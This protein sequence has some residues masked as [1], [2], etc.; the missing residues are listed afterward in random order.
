M[1][2]VFLGTPRTALPTLEALVRSGHDVTRVVTRPD[3]PAGRSGKAI[4]PPVKVL[5]EELG[6]SV[7]QPGKIRGAAFLEELRE[8]RPEALVV[9][10]YGRI[11]PEP[12]LQLAPARAINLHF[13]LLPRYRGAAPVQWALANG[14]ESTG[15]TTM[16]ISARLDE[17]DLLLQEEVAIRN[18]E[19]NPELQER[20]AT[21][22]A[23]LVLRTL[24][25]QAAGKLDA[26]P[27]D[28]ARA[29][30]APILTAAD[31]EIDPG[32][33]A[34]EIE[35][36]VRGFD[37]WPGVWV[38]NGG[39]RLRLIEVEK[40]EQT[41]SGAPPGEVLEL[42]GEGLVVACGE[43]TRLSVIRIQPEGR[44]VIRARDAVNGRQLRPGDRLEKLE[45]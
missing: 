1:R 26:R 35:G 39:R 13:S 36:R 18:G 42:A 5:A 23:T 10:A 33:T 17:G 2:L 29:T 15:V 12:V 44:R 37:P 6:L 45:R 38:G 4:P 9:V 43:G 22:G 27:Q 20:L 32:L 8:Q 28:P 7:Q 41:A 19:R 34:R 31:G 11:L 25:E 30:Y 16:Q 40:L 24:E 3:R 14:E 21:I